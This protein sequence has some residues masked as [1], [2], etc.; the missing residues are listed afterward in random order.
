MPRASRE[1]IDSFF[2]SGAYAVIGVSSDQKK[3]GNIVYRT[4]KE[5]SAVVY[6]VHPSLES[7]EG[8]ACYRNVAALPPEVHSVITVVPPAVTAA[9]V[10][11]CAARGIAHIWM[12]PG[13]ESAAAI[14]EAE[15]AGI[16]VIPGECIL[17]FLEP[18]ESFHAFHR[19]VK[20]VVGRYPR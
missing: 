8:D 10:K 6:P 20:K 1:T 14:A 16:R 15:K 2:T 18:V 12:Q 7:V 17:M 3:F 19:F 4:M 11:E 5:K 13:S 9:V